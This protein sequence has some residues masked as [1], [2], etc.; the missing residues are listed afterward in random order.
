[1]FYI[2]LW[3]VATKDI[4]LQTFLAFPFPSLVIRFEVATL[5]FFSLAGDGSAIGCEVGSTTT[6]SYYEG[7]KGNGLKI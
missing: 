6:S 1:M 2:V 4:R 7:E 3:I 5:D